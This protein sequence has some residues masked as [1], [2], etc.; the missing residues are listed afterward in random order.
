MPVPN[1]ESIATEGKGDY[2]WCQG[3]VVDT[4][5]RPIANAIIDTWETDEHGL[6][7]TQVGKDL[8]ATMPTSQNLPV[9]TRRHIV[10]GTVGARLSR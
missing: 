9:R 10:F 7:D 5:G 8:T 6:Y 3:R 1:G 2:L 4:A